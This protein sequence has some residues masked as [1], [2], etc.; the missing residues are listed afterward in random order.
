MYIV[1]QPTDFAK[2]FA[3]DFLRDPQRRDSDLILVRNVWRLCKNQ[4]LTSLPWRLALRPAA[5]CRLAIVLFLQ[6]F[7]VVA[8]AY[9]AGEPN[10]ESLATCRDSWLDWKDNPARGAKFV[11]DMHTGYTYKQDRGGFL[12]PKAPRSVLGLSV[13]GVYPESAGMAVGFSVLVNVGF[14]AARKAVEKTLGKPMKCDDKSDEMLTCERELGAK[15][16][17]FVMAE[18]KSAKSALIGCY[19]FYEK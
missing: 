9:A 8:T 14:D 10:L 4:I 2:H 13:A 12:V 1:S 7:L 11:E 16:T 6:L 15:K 19:Y 3:N 18:D 5:A 17:V